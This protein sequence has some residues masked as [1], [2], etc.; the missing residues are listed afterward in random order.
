MQ[1]DLSANQVSSGS[2]KLALCGR[3]LRYLLP[4]YGTGAGIGRDTTHNGAWCALHCRDSDQAKNEMAAE[5]M[6][7]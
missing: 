7:N 5:W 3:G 2:A 1:S 6:R 4:G